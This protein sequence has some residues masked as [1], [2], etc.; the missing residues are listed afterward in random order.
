M[1]L[2]I[3]IDDDGCLQMR[4]G[5]KDFDYVLCPF[6]RSSDVKCGDW[7]ALFREPLIMPNAGDVSLSLCHSLIM[8]GINEF[9]DERGEG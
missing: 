4:R 8:C 2:K 3:K 6:D 9:A 7:C 5:K 1:S